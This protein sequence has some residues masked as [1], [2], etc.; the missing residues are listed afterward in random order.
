EPGAFF[1]PE[2][3]A[4]PQAMTQA[5]ATAFERVIRRHPSLWCLN[6][7]RWRYMMEGTAHPE[8][9]PFYAKPARKAPVKVG[10]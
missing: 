4:S 7:R 2:A 3:F 1:Q 9:Y 6:Y 5:M 10:G 8:R